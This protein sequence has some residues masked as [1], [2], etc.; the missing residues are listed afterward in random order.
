M[1][2]EK[3]DEKLGFL[4]MLTD[5]SREYSA[6]MTT[7]ERFV[8][9]YKEQFPTLEELE[10][11]LQKLHTAAEVEETENGKIVGTVFREEE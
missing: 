9:K 1:H 7:V 2:I 8:A 6:Y 4:K 11:S 5:L 3:Y 10:K